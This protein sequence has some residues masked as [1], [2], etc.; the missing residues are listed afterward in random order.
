[1]TQPELDFTAPPEKRPHKRV[2]DT[3]KL[4]YAIGRET[5]EGRK[6][7]ALRHLA[8]YWNRFN[9]SPTSAE[10]TAWTDKGE[11][12]FPSPAFQVALL[13]M[14]RGLSDL[15]RLGLAEPHHKRICEFTGRLVETWRVREA[16]SQEPR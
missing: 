9:H 14:R 15:K 12:L 8:A 4:A 3:S 16:G 5:F 7:D 1:M 13:R 11:H 6:A 10:L 2:R